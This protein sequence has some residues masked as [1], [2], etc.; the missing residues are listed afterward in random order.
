MAEAYPRFAF[1]R[2][3]RSAHDAQVTPCRSRLVPGDERIDD[4]VIAFHPQR[5]RTA[6][7]GARRGVLAAVAIRGQRRAIAMR[8]A[9][10]KK[11]RDVERGI[12]HVARP[13]DRIAVERAVT[14]LALGAERELLSWTCRW[15][16]RG[17]RSRESAR[18]P[19]HRA[20]SAS[21]RRSRRPPRAPSSRLARAHASR[22]RA[23][24]RAR[25]RAPPRSPPG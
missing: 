23:S 10:R 2:Q 7:A 11:L 3:P 12:E 1:R 24:A 17:N 25:A 15:G 18:S 13:G 21:W 8:I 9:R 14:D 4:R 5:R 16:S 20:G 22:R 19:R 6:A